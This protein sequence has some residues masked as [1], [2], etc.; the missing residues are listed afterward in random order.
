[1]TLAMII[2]ILPQIHK[3]SYRLPSS[4]I[5]KIL[6]DVQHRPPRR[7]GRSQTLNQDEIITSSGP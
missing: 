7:A 1:M 2:R 5:E 6:S 3:A 4:C